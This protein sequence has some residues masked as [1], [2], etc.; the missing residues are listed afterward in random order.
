MTNIFIVVLNFNGGQD[1]IDCLESLRK[2]V[3][4]VVVV[5]NR[6]TDNSLAQI[7]KKFPKVKI[8]KNKKNLGFAA[9]NNAGI[10]YALGQSK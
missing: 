2:E 4:K 10:K 5:D 6:S 7:R 3:A 8:I 9:G 1:V